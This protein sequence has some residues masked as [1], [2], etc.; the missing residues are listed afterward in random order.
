MFDCVP[1][2]MPLLCRPHSLSTN[3]DLSI[4]DRKLSTWLYV[5]NKLKSEAADHQVSALGSCKELLSA[6]ETRICL[7]EQ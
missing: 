2:T 4:F 5:A 6:I 7:D 3:F 1:K